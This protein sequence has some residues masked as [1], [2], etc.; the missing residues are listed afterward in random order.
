MD[1]DFL[2]VILFN[3]IW[4]IFPYCCILGGVRDQVRHVSPTE[5]F[6]QT[7]AGQGSL[8]HRWV[9]KRQEGMKME[10]NLL[11]LIN[12]VAFSS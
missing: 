12:F 11:N 7:H 3:I 9:R 6:V 1:I 2:E 10:D 4:W 8:A 5:G